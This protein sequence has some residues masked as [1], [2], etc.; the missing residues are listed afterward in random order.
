MQ[1]QIY[2]PE[3][4]WS[5]MIGCIIIV[6]A[7]QSSTRIGNAY[8][9]AI[10][11]VMVIDTILLS[12]VMLIDWNWNVFIAALFLLVYSFISC[13]YLSSNLLKVPDGAWF[14]IVLSGILSVVCYVYWWG[15]TCKVRYIRGH[16]VKLGDVLE[17]DDGEE[18]GMKRVV[19][20]GGY[21]DSPGTNGE[22]RGDGLHRRCASRSDHPGSKPVSLENRDHHAPGSID[23]LTHLSTASMTPKLY[24]GIKPIR[25]VGTK[26]PV[27]RL[28][29]LGFYYSELIDG[30]PPLFLKYLTLN[31]AIHE[32]VIVVTIRSVPLPALP[33]DERLLIR[34]LNLEGFYHVIARYGYTER[35]CQ[36][37]EFARI[38]VD[39]VLEYL[40]CQ[41]T[42]LLH[43][44]ICSVHASTGDGVGVGDAGGRDIEEGNQ[45]TVTSITSAAT[46]Q[47]D[48]ANN[49]DS[50]ASSMR[51]RFRQL[52]SLMRVKSLPGQIGGIEAAPDGAGT[53]AGEGARG[54]L[55]ELMVSVGRDRA[56]RDGL[57]RDM[58]RWESSG[59]AEDLARYKKAGRSVVSSQTET[60]KR[61]KTIATGTRS[62][63]SALSDAAATGASGSQFPWMRQPS[64]I[65]RLLSS[66]R[67]T[68]DGGRDTYMRRVWKENGYSRGA[69]RLG[70]EYSY[71]ETSSVPLPPPPPR[72]RIHR[73]AGSDTIQEHAEHQVH[74]KGPGTVKG[75]GVED[76][77]GE[78]PGSTLVGRS[79]ES[80]QRR[81]QE[82]RDKG[83]LYFVIVVIV[84]Y[85]YV[86]PVCMYIITS[87]CVHSMDH[88]TQ[89]LSCTAAF[90]NN[91]TLAAEK[92][93]ILT[94]YS[95]GLVHLIGRADLKASGKEKKV[96]G[97][98]R[99]FVINSMYA[100][101][102]S[103]SRP[104][105]ADYNIPM[106]T[107]LE[108]RSRYEV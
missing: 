52:K 82:E 56:S 15:Q 42:E 46:S 57:V 24:P 93:L 92:G 53:P 50:T 58:K 7:F 35:V 98:F 19:K 25:L 107:M 47:G 101:L 88:D 49:D 105:A 27:A 40:E 10:A 76:M 60:I 39:E 29:G 21:A 72:P 73:R 89:P 4:N 84:V 55:P 31:P 106:E 3:V 94:A 66:P 69:S 13:A 70:G 83:R 26:L 51:A 65:N 9:L 37:E 90:K 44:E 12:I 78:S 86:Q 71:D 11:T 62:T 32:C 20:Y 95:H 102:S 41:T 14:S 48:S 64:K 30:L 108:T 18:A 6:A 97:V 104:A 63:A 87:Q 75:G 77:V 8:G 85:N 99:R 54:L 61:S 2:I 22:S 33:D 67:K 5:L 103:N 28:P 17:L 100:F 91:D 34:K 59:D 45:F 74:D 81:L 43:E 80:L 68:L 16:M 23:T 1:G 96:T 79:A 36:G 38:V